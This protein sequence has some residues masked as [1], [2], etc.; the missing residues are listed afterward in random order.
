VPWR[1]AV[2]V[3]TVLLA[4]AALAAPHCGTPMALA[5]LQ[6]REVS[7]FAGVLSP[8]A[9]LLEPAAPP[10]PDGRPVQGTRMDH[11]VDSAH[12]TVAW[13]DGRGDRAAAEAASEA[14]ERAWT[15]LVEDE[16]F[17]APVSSDAFLLW[18]VLDPTLGAVGLTTEYANAAYPEGYP[19]IFLDPGWSGDADL[20]ASVAT[21]ELAHA[22]QFAYRDYSG[23]ASQA[24]EPWYWEASAEWSAAI[25][26]PDLSV[27]ARSSEHYARAPQLPHWVMEDAHQYGMFVVNATLEEQLRGA[28]AMREVWEGS[29]D[30]PSDGWPTLL[31]DVAGLPPAAVF[32]WTAVAYAMGRLE[33]AASYEAVT[34]AGVLEDGVMGSVGWLG[35]QLY[36]ADHD[37]TVEVTASAGS[38]SLA[39]EGSLGRSVQV[40]AGAVVA[41]VGTTDGENTYQL[42]ISPP[43]TS[44][45]SGGAGGGGDAPRSTE[46]GVSSGFGVED[47]GGCATASSQAGPAATVLTLVLGLLLRCGR[48]RT[49]A[50]DPGA[51]R[52]TG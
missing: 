12:F 4:S 31:S 23:G 11:H 21:H 22:I 32:G 29:A 10:P 50:S 43:V 1:Y 36:L 34:M 47:S 15:A 40:R 26:R 27:Y 30:R 7:V 41:V 2:S 37:A 5:A 19:V 13:Q 45:G 42:S 18:V 48:R 6:G 3:L 38:V 46:T 16:G 9:A 49:P 28:G 52:R 44:G 14:L 33:D 39:V 25:A 17:R 20:W 8:P 51:S 35:A 24:R